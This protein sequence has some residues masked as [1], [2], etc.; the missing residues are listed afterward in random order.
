MQS[1]YILTGSIASGKSTVLEIIKNEGYNT[2]S[3]DKIVKELYTSE[4]FLLK[5]K[6]IIGKEFFT[7]A[8]NLDIVKLRKKLFADAAFK[9]KVE[10]YV[11]PLVYKRVAEKL[12]RDINFIEV[13][14]FFEAKKYFDASK[15]IISGVIYVYADE[16][17]E[18]ARLIK[19]NNLSKSEAKLQIDK[20]LTTKEKLALSDY[21]ID[22]S[23]DLISLKE[24]VLKTL[25]K[26]NEK[27]I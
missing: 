24:E 12:S 10:A 17:T 19:R 15:I 25:E 2:I 20:R 23:K 14:L 27:N 7:N 22:N 6:E 11:H 8:L 4:E 18:L 13:P 21:I 1:N 5:F 9:E 3:A 16:N 26:I